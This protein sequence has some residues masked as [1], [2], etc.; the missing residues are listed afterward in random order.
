[1]SPS[2]GRPTSLANN[3]EPREAVTCSDWQDKLPQV[4]DLR[5]SDLEGIISTSVSLLPEA[6]YITPYATLLTA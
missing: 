1:M 2:H 4:Q 3:P 6:D 5:I